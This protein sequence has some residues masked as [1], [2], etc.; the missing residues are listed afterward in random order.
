[1]RVFMGKPD[2]T[3]KQ[4]ARPAARPNRRSPPIKL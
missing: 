4:P 2:L 3:L 1:M